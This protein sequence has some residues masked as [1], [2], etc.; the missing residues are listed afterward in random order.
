MEPLDTGC[1]NARYG[2][3]GT[4][5]G[6][7]AE[8][9]NESRH[10]LPA[11]G[12]AADFARDHGANAL[13]PARRGLDTYAWDS[14]QAAIARLQEFTAGLALHPEVREVVRQPTGPRRF[15]V[16]VRRF[17]DR[18]LASHPA[19]AL[20]PGG[21]LFYRTFTRARSDASDPGN[22]D[23]RL[24]DGELLRLF[25][26]LQL[27]V[28]REGAGR[29]HARAAQSGARRHDWRAPAVGGGLQ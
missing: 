29:S 20:P 17:L 21:L 2:D 25:G 6:S 13:L 4:T 18:S 27:R 5:L 15:D 11:H 1:W 22:P 9:L 3:A 14:A 23:F 26:A 8:V 24:A 7:A 28:Y 10:L 16:I 19:A 12:C